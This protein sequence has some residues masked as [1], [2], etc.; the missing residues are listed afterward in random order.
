MHILYAER[1]LVHLP[2]IVVVF[3]DSVL[4]RD[5]V[6]LCQHDLRLFV[7]ERFVDLQLLRVCIVNSGFLHPLDLS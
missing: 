6:R 1:R 3:I 7:P 5:P 2:P 4:R